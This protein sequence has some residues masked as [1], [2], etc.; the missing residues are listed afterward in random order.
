MY[1]GMTESFTER[2]IQRM[3]LMKNQTFLDIGSGIGQV[4]LQ[5]AATVGCKAIGIE[6]STLRHKA[7]KS[8]VEH[9]DAVL[10]KVGAIASR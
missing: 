6:I 7:A 4:V 1:G 5:V 10:D 3:R 9:F 2:L 8:L